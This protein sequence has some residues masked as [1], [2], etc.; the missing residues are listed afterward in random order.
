MISQNYKIQ[1]VCH[2]IDFAINAA[3]CM[4]RLVACPCG[5]YSK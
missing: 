5:F 4:F 1:S 2:A 3:S